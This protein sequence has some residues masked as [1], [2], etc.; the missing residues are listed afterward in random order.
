MIIE[1]ILNWF[2]SIF[3][4]AVSL[5]PANGHLFDGVPKLSFTFMKY[6]ATLNGYIPIVEIGKVFV[7]M[8]AIQASLLV[9]RMIMGTYNYITKVIP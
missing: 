1:Q 7:I 9:I 8:V 5:L 4:F 2:M 3:Q 6:V